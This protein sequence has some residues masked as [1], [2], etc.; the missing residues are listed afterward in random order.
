MFFFFSV[1]PSSL[2]E[3]KAAARSPT[4]FAFFGKL[5]PRR[6]V[7]A[8]SRLWC[9]FPFAARIALL[10]RSILAAGRSSVDA[11]PASVL[12]GNRSTE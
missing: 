8:R 7:H 9:R 1:A 5:W 11:C 3:R 10:A 4:S 6:R 2:F 12:T